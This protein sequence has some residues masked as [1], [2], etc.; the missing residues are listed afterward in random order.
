[1]PRKSKKQQRFKESAVLINVKDFYI[2]TADFTAAEVGYFFK[3]LCLQWANKTI[4][5][6][7]YRLE[8][9]MGSM[10]SAPERDVS[11]NVR[12]DEDVHVPIH[13][14]FRTCWEH[15]KKKFVPHRDG[16]LVNLRM[17]EERAEFMEYQ[18]SQ[19]DRTKAAT[20]A[21]LEK[22]RN[23][24]RDVPRTERRNEDADVLATSDVTR[25]NTNTNTNSIY[26]NINTGEQ[27]ESEIKNK[28]PTA[29]FFAA[30]EKFLQT[31]QGE[32]LKLHLY[33]D[34]GYTSK[35]IEKLLEQNLERMMMVG[36][37]WQKPADFKV[38]VF[39]S[40]FREIV[41][42]GEESS[43]G[44]INKDFIWWYN[45]SLKRIEK[46][47]N[48]SKKNVDWFYAELAKAN[49]TCK[50]EDVKQKFIDYY[51]TPTPSGSHYFQTLQNF[52][53]KEYLAQWVAKDFKTITK[54]KLPA[55]TTV[56]PGA[57]HTIEEIKD[58]YKQE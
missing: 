20:E 27:A 33:L 40:Y 48:N 46:Q 31:G 11:R 17:E 24:K 12:R 58:H 57:G 38:F 4:P 2:D 1:M 3:L 10:G 15:I 19:Q 55:G 47:Y 29:G 6:D 30:A 22:Q 16:G 9:A 34:G 21:R 23:E 5:D 51:L 26:N 35:E 56:L 45:N 32:P 52:D 54:L 28:Q 37:L 42:S 25:T 44:K 18:Q 36:D 13:V 43:A 14:P 39:E 41:A 7:V 49:G 50:K 8:I 53:V